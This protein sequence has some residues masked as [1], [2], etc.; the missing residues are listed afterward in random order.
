MLIEALFFNKPEL[1]MLI[2]ENLVVWGNMN[3]ELKS[4]IIAYNYV[5]STNREWKS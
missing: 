5:S 1:L 2:I 4:D 3:A